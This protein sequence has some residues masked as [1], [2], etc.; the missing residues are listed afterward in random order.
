[1]LNQSRPLYNAYYTGRRRHVDAQDNQIRQAVSEAWR[2][3]IEGEC[4]VNTASH[5][6]LV[7]P[8]RTK[9]FVASKV[10]PKSAALRYIEEHF[11][12]KKR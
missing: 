8:V 6:T 9:S 1:M 4:T 7:S 5:A 12:S 11:F 3:G 10:K 2:K